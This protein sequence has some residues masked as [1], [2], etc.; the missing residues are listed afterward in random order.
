MQ[1]KKYIIDNGNN[2]ALYTA[3]AGIVMYPYTRL[4][5]IAPVCAVVVLAALAGSGEGASRATTTSTY[6]IRR[7][8]TLWDLAFRFL[9]NPFDWPRIWRLN[10]SISDPHW[11][12]PGNELVLVPGGYAFARGEGGRGQ[13]PR[14]SFSQLTEGFLDHTRVYSPVA[15]VPAA[16]GPLFEGGLGSDGRARLTRE[17][18]QRL[19]FLCTQPDARGSLC[20][21]IGE[22]DPR[23]NARLFYRFDEAAVRIFTPGALK[24]GDTLDIFSCGKS[25][26]VNDVRARVSARIGRA[27]VVAAQEGGGS[28]RIIDVW[29]VIEPGSRIG[30]ATASAAVVVEGYSRPLS[31]TSATVVYRESPRMLAFPYETLIINRGADAGIGSG[32][33][34]AVFSP[35]KQEASVV[36]CAALV[37]REYSTL[38]VVRSS[39]A[40]FEPGY[41]AELVMRAL[42]PQ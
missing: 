37:E 24:A 14:L 34:F 41:R 16:A 32:D 5:R 8:D 42:A 31:A 1:Y 19:P 18:L 2:G 36:A 26:K 3:A 20:P 38:V 12:Y 30:S 17:L 35:D 4:R 23:G 21:G 7:G 6:L 9:G 22:I 10:P 29:G 39:E 33:L 13:A 28:I 11:I 27:E 15:T 40:P 25:L